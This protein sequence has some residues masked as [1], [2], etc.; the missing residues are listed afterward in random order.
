MSET[1]SV[2]QSSCYKCLPIVNDNFITR[3][4]ALNTINKG[5]IHVFRAHWS[6]MRPKIE[7]WHREPEHCIGKVNNE[8]K[9]MFVTCALVS[10]WVFLKGHLNRS[11]NGLPCLT[12][13]N[14]RSGGEGAWERGAWS[15]VRRSVNNDAV[16]MFRL[17]ITSQRESGEIERVAVKLKY[18][19]I[20]P[21]V[22]MVNMETEYETP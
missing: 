6:P 22:L 16:I 9:N 5:K 14:L 19:I 20:S 11:E 3:Q 18:E 1:F 10:F 4:L 15:Q 12:L 21:G 8:N 2:E 7:H 13:R 17:T